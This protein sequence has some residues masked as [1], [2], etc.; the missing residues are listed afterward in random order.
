M[1]RS[2]ARTSALFSGVASVNA[3]PTACALPVLPIR[4]T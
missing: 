2:I 4:C 1:K 3:S